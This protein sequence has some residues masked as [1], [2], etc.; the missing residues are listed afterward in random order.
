MRINRILAAA[1]VASAIAGCSS[2]GGPAKKPLSNI[3]LTGAGATFPYPIYSKWFDMYHESTG[4]QI[5]YQS[6]GSGGGIQQLKAGTVDFGASDA[7]LN[8]E[9][10]GEMP[11]PV[12][13]IPTVAGAVVLAYNIPDLAQPLQ[14][15]PK[16]LAGI[17]MGTVK[18]WN[19][20]AIKAANP[21]V[22]LPATAVLAVHRSD[23]SGTSN[24]FTTYLSAVSPDWKSKVGA[25]TSVAWPAGVGAKGNEGVTGQVKQT[26]GSI[27]YVELAYA[28]QNNLTVA[29]LQ[30]SSGAYID[31]SLASTTA[32]IEASAQALAADV[33]ASTVNAAGPDA[34]P[35][36]ALTFILV[37]QDQ[38]DEAKAKALADFL[39]WAIH[40]GQDQVEALQYARLPAAIVQVDE[41]EIARLTAA[42]KP[43]ASP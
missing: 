19:D 26:P 13:H 34:Y 7:P 15:T 25:N 17:F 37:Y 24:I 38:A 11:H 23:G 14:L 27:G 40:Q 30:N 29:R 2:G 33:R 28:K 10:L 42:G 3:T 16:A 9:K 6:I 41:Q 18:T 1:L 8:D 39:T 4:V 21:G 22:T 36:A 20:P 5:N 32:A 35:I 12:V 43:L 31:P